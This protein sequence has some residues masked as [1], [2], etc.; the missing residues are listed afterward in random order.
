MKEKTNRKQ[1]VGKEQPL[2]EQQRELEKHW[3]RTEMYQACL[4]KATLET[5]PIE[6]LPVRTTLEYMDMATT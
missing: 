4:N 2:Q 5:D 3:N 1:K 6:G